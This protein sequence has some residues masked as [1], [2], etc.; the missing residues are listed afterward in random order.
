LRAH[1]KYSDTKPF[2]CSY[3][4]NRCELNP[5]TALD[6]TILILSWNFNYLREEIKKKYIY[7][8]IYQNG[9]L[10]RL[11]AHQKYSEINFHW[12]FVTPCR[13]TQHAASMIWRSSLQLISIILEVPGW[14]FIQCMCIPFLVII[15]FWAFL[16]IR[17]ESSWSIVPGQ[18]QLQFVR[19][20]QSQDLASFSN[21]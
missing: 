6:F 15:T 13:R 21:G 7:I 11:L 1:K 17:I 12:I 14:L 2:T 10:D 20:L 3:R 8:Y 18:P 5:S 9:W 16:Y 19:F 4:P